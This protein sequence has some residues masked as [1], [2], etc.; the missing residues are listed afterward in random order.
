LPLPDK[1]VGAV[2]VAIGVG[3][4]GRAARAGSVAKTGLPK[5]PIGIVHT[6]IVV[7]ISF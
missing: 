2:A 7:E 4:A 6:P 1:Q 5:I 3:V